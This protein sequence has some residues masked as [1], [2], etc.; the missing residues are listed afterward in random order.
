MEKGGQSEKSGG[1]GRGDG[2]TRRPRKRNAAAAN[3][4]RGPRLRLPV[5]TP[6]AVTLSG[7]CSA[8]SKRAALVWRL[9]V[10]ALVN[11]GA[12]TQP[13]WPPG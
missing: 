11:Q 3:A 1:D 9:L 12:G 6:A 5:R 2:E 4:V 8:I 13:M 10:R 7:V